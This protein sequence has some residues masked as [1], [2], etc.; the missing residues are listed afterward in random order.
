MSMKGMTNFYD[1]KLDLFERLI[2][3]T[4]IKQ[5]FSDLVCILD[6]NLRGLRP[7]SGLSLRLHAST[8]FYLP[9]FFVFPGWTQ[10]H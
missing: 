5:R 2:E 9:L 6:G 8:Y 7:F 10:Y 4:M 1:Y 3:S